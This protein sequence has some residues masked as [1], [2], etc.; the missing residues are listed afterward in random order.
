MTHLNAL[1]FFY[2]VLAIVSCERVL[3]LVVSTR[4]ARWSLAHGG[5]ESGRGHYPFMVLLH[6]CLLVGCLAEVQLA[7]RPFLAWVGLPAFAVVIASQL[8]RW[9]CIRTL[10]RQ[11]STR[12]I[13]V[14]GSDRVVSGPYRWWSHP[15]YAAVVAEGFA[16][17]LI[18]SAWTTAVVFTVLN[19]WLLRVRL[20]VEERA[21]ADLKQVSA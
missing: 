18:H 6:G 7:D 10:G 12:V 5:V 21:L 9:W 16:L 20:G 11:W 2:V 8:L 3:E 15:N 1:L 13:V 14:P 4:N 17:P 19:F